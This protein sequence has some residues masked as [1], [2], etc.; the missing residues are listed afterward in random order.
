MEWL[1]GETFVC[2]DNE[3]ANK[4]TFS[5]ALRRRCVTLDGDSYDPTGTVSGGQY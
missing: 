4:I 3:S 2:V 5:D 1:F